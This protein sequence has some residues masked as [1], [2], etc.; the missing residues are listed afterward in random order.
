[1]D[2]PNF[3]P[4][5]I[6]LVDSNKTCPKVVKFFQTAPTWYQHIWR[7]IR[8]TQEKVLYYH[9]G[10]FADSS[11]IIEQQSKVVLKSAKKLLSTHNE[12]LIIRKK[13]IT[14]AEQI[15]LF[16]VALN[17]LEETYDIV[18]CFGKFF[19]WLTGIKFFAR[20]MQLPNQD[21]CINRVCYWYRKALNETFGFKTHSE[22]TTHT[23]YKY[24]MSHLDQWTIVYRG[25]PQKDKL[26]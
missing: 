2:K 22:I 15:K 23:L 21:I 1:M 19:T 7:K 4:G 17:D 24:V 14:K 6:F 8:G 16:S 25:I 5:D 26:I 10:M 11:N 18:N 3:L 13:G 12:V 9:V 20:Y